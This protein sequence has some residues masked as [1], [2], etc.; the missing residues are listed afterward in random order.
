MSKTGDRAHD[1][2]E[3]YRGRKVPPIQ[4]INDDL[5]WDTLPIDEP[6]P[7]NVGDQFDEI[8]GSHPEKSDNSGR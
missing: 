1:R 8:F 6:R 4:A 5:D 7:R 3:E 2:R